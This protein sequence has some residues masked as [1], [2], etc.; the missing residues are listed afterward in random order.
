MDRLKRP[1]ERHD[2]WPGFVVAVIGALALV[3]GLRRITGIETVAG[4]S[5]WETQLVKAFSSGG[6]QYETPA[7]PTGPAD[8]TDPSATAA[9]L[10]QWEQAATGGP[11]TRRHVR[12]NTS[13]AT[14]CPT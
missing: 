1:A 2:F 12:I 6:L 14:P 8:A 9:T 10:K 11:G 3:G 13:A 7:L 5:A 4:N